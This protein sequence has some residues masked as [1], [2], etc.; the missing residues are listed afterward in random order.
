MTRVT[1]SDQ[2][3]ALL[4]AELR[5]LQRARGGRAESKQ[6]SAVKDA[7]ATAS[8]APAGA[9]EGSRDP[10]ATLVAALLLEEW[11]PELGASASFQ[12]LVVGVVAALKRDPEASDLLRLVISA[13]TPDA[14]DR[15]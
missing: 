12:N 14:A 5:R 15:D 7:E 1:T 2:A 3:L 9:R 10:A 6:K 13:N 4:R 8:A 11:G